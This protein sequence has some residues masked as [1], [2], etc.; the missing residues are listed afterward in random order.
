K[1]NAAI[2]A[3]G[4]TNTSFRSASVSASV[5]TNSDGT[6]QLV[7][8]ST[9]SAFQVQAGSKTANALLGNFQSGATNPGE[10]A[11]VTGTFLNST[12]TTAAGASGAEAVKLQVTLNG[13][14]HLFSVTISNSDSQATLLTDVTSATD[15]GG[16]TLAQLGVT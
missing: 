6:Q 1:I 13:V 11:D 8:S 3:A 2:N 14:A 16:K 9:K 15:A 10:G 12:A 4:N 5:K 7:F